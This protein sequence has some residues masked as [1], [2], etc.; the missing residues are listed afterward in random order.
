MSRAEYKTVEV[1]RWRW[2]REWSADTATE[3]QYDGLGM[4]VVAEY[5]DR[6]YRPEIGNAWL[7]WLEGMGSRPKWG[8][9]RTTRGHGWGYG[10]GSDK[11]RPVSE[12]AY[13]NDLVSRMDWDPE[14]SYR[15]WKDSDYYHQDILGSTTLLTVE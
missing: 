13:G 1:S 3:Y 12:Y 8:T 9:G 14:R 7:P 11:Y 15:S 6:D 4:Q 5:R 2:N 10:L